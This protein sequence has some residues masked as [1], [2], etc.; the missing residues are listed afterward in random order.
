M[1]WGCP[2]LTTVASP[3]STRLFCT[4]K[5]PRISFKVRG[6]CPSADLY[7]GNLADLSQWTSLMSYESN[8]FVQTTISL[9]NLWLAIL[10]PK[11]G[12]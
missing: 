8:P 4:E 2:S 5:D 6:P 11:L 12:A 7:C 1:A 3:P 9:K 10:T